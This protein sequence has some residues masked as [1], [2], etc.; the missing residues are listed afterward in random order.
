MC[1]DSDTY[2]AYN[3]NIKTWEEKGMKRAVAIALSTMMFLQP[4]TASAVTWGNIVNGLRNSGTNRYTEDGTTIEKDGDSY[5][6]SGGTIEDN[7]EVSFYYFGEKANIWLKNLEINGN[8]YI[9]AEDGNQFKIEIDKGTILKKSIDGYA[10]GEKS[11]IDL[12][13]YGKINDLFIYAEDEGCVEA[14]NGGIISGSFDG[15]TQGS[16]SKVEIENT[17]EGTISNMFIE[18]KNGGYT[19][20]KNDGT[21]TD[22]FVG[23]STGKN[24]ETKIENTEK[25]KINDMQV[26]AEDGGY[27]SLSSDG[28]LGSFSGM[29]EG[30]KSKTEIK[31]EKNGKIGDFWIEADGQESRINAIN[32]G[33]INGDA[34]IGY[35]REF[36]ENGYEISFVNN[37]YVS[38]SLITYLG[39]GTTYI[40]NNGTIE[41]NESEGNTTFMYVGVEEGTTREE[42]IRQLGSK[43]NSQGN[44]NVY[45]FEFR[46]INDTDWDNVNGYYLLLNEENNSEYQEQLPDEATQKASI[47]HE[48]EMKRQE[49]AIGG[50]YGSPYWVKQLYLGYHSL[51][52]RLF[53]G[54]KRVNFKE[55][56]D[57]MPDGTKQITLR[58]N[59][60]APKKLTMR[61]DER[62]L[63]TLER[64][65]FS[66][67]TLT[68]KSG[69]PIMQ[70]SLA[71]L[72][73]AY[74]QYGLHD[75]DQ[76]VV[77]GTND[78]VLKIVDGEMKPIEE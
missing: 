74:D 71:D 43:L 29:A 42:I 21:I 70:Y 69:V 40:E 32:D 5:T 22:Y 59:T 55:E 2:K 33:E 18:S 53:I 58:V 10:K 48:M 45:V 51:N 46:K 39:K 77:G 3:N 25:S 66:I 37:G 50:V 23:V 19:E 16:K 15:R 9:V 62:V 12:I 11:N 56:L 38:D 4:M 24:S 47:C 13:N 52:L 1:I 31:N 54:E 57:W 67:I 63:E 78:D 60:D 27:T 64:T 17:K 61:L 20:A 8:F 41:L 6:I 76:M 65:N 68:D 35:V 26:R 73:S 7:G 14:Q 44:Q 34:E 30:D 28:T 72:R 75:V 36:E 49:E